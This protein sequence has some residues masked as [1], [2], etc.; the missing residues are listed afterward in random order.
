MFAG[1]VQL[2]SICDVDI[3]AAA[4][5]V[6][7]L[8]AVG[9]VVFVVSEAVFDG[10]LVPILLIADTRYVYVVF[11]LRPASEYVEFVFPVSGT[12][13]DQVVPLSVDLSIL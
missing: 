1:L 2:R 13:M 6:G 8:G 7:G 9:V 10:A 4:S 5:P 11:A 12:M 3:A